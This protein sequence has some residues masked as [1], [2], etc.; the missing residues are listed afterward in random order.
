MQTE[1]LKTLAISDSSFIFD[2]HPVMLLTQM[3][4][5]KKGDVYDF[6]LLSARG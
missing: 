4:Q 6:M 3:K 2:H 1:R 5:G